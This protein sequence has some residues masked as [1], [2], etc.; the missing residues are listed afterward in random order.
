[1]LLC[2]YRDVTVILL[3]VNQLEYDLK[4][5]EQKYSITNE[6]KMALEEQLDRM[7]IQKSTLESLLEKEKN[8][9]RSIQQG[10]SDVCFAKP[11]MVCTV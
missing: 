9:K 2:G 3:Q 8:S 11:Y 10:L 6:H 4:T 5:A 7:R 1:M